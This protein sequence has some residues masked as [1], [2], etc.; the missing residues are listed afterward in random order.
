MKPVQL[1]AST[2][3][4]FASRYP[5]YFF[6]SIDNNYLQT[7]SLRYPMITLCVAFH[8]EYLCMLIMFGVF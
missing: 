6:I 2:D 3:T 1:S 4:L 8:H 5:T 7:I